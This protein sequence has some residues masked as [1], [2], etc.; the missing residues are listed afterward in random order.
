MRVFD[1]YYFNIIEKVSF[2]DTKPYLDHMLEELGYS[3]RDISFMLWGSN[4]DD[5]TDKVLTKLPSLK[6]YYF[7]EGDSGSKDYGVT[8]FR[9]NWQ[10]GNVRADREDWDDI[11]MLFS[12]IPRPY[13]YPFGKLILDGI[14]WFEDSDNSVAITD[15]VHGRDTYPT[16]HYPPFISNRIM[17]LRMYD[18][19][20][21]YNR[22]SVTIE[23]TDADGIRDSKAIIDKLTPYLGEGGGMSREC[24]FEKEEY[25]LYMEFEKAHCK[26]LKEIGDSMLPVPRN[27]KSVAYTTKLEHVADKAVV[28]KAFKGTGFER[29]KG[30]PN[31]LHLYYMKDDNGY[32]YDA[33]V[34][35]ISIGNEFRCWI[36]IWGYNFHVKYEHPDYYVDQEGESLPILK[37]FASFCRHLR[38]T[39]GEELRKDYG[40][41][42]DWYWRS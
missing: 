40:A 13:N 9:E 18:D 10:D 34:Q 30:Q 35:K 39:Y 36:E 16:V 23:V 31:W 24:A 6:K 3:Y 41:T 33:F 27:M 32:E 22:I 19:G 14:N 4:R 15:W 11:A 26:R 28:N 8:S 38:D 5:V 1:T 7:M 12:K 2:K 21:K 42:P 29:V 37:E 25:I 20:R 17:Q